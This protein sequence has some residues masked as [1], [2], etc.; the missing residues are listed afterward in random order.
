MELKKPDSHLSDYL[1]FDILRKIE[2][3]N[4][5][6]D[7]VR[8]LARG[9]NSEAKSFNK[10]MING[11]SYRTKDHEA[12]MKIQNSGVCVTTED[13]VTY[14]GILKEIIEL[15]YFDKYKVLLFRC[16]WVDVISGRGCMKDEFGFTLVN[17]KRLIHCG[18]QLIHE[19][20]ILASQAAQVYYVEDEMCRDWHVVVKTRP[21][22]LFHMGD[23]TFCES[24]RFVQQTL[25][26][27]VEDDNEHMIWTRSDMEGPTIDNQ[28]LKTNEVDEPNS[29]EDF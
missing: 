11:Y 1:V 6:F 29:E 28:E 26:N 10:C 3:V 22:D 12:S 2:G 9:P 5:Q 19:P 20:F 23:Y 18:D 24:E 13:G 8:L 15:N 27:I 25:G 14:Y 7:E 17:Y 4:T 16:D 21:K